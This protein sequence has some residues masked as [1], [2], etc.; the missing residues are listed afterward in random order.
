MKKESM[1]NAVIKDFNLFMYDHTS[2]RKHFCRYCLPAFRAA[3]KLKCHIKELK[4][5]L[6]KV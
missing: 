3:E 4:L 1:H 6:S 2:A 5:M